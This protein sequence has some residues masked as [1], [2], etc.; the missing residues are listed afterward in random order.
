MLHRRSTTGRAVPSTG[1]A[2]AV[3]FLAVLALIGCAESP[4]TLRIYFTADD[5]GFLTPCG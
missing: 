4:A 3:V 2:A 1:F 5:A